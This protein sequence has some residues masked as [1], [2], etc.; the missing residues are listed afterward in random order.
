MRRPLFL[1]PF[2]L[3]GCETPPPKLSGSGM[4][5]FAPVK[6]RLH[7][8]SRIVIPSTT[9]ATAPATAPA[10]SSTLPPPPVL[11]ARLELTD[12]FGDAGKGIGD[13]AIE[14][15]EPDTANARGKRL[16]R[17]EVS[18]N[19]PELNRDRWDRTTRTYFFRVPVVG[20]S[21]DREQYLVTVT[22]TLPNQAVLTDQIQLPAR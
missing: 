2:L 10:T 3:L 12:Q 20:V 7:P 11:E 15:Y 18:L 19:A 21:R 4:D 16:A 22:V 1:L 17:L 5:M 9:P 13:V 14:V 8:L 6:V